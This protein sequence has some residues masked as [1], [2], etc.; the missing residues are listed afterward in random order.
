MAI[1]QLLL[2]NN[3]VCILY[4]GKCWRFMVWYSSP[5]QSHNVYFG[6]AEASGSLRDGVGMKKQDFILRFLVMAEFK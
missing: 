1:L 4:V 6:S 3:A 5:R 2:H